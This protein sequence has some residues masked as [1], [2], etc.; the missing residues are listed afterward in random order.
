MPNDVDKSLLDRLQALRGSSVTPERISSKYTHLSERKC[1]QTHWLY[2]INID[3]IERTRTPTREDALA[4]RLKSLRSQDTPSP[5]A[6]RQQPIAEKPIRPKQVT[7]TSSKEP[8]SPKQDPQDQAEDDDEAMFR[9][10]DNVLEELLGDVDTE[11]NYAKPT[12]PSDD[13]VKAFLEELSRSVPQNDAAA[14][15]SAD[16]EDKDKDSDDSDGQDMT[17]E[18]DDVVA[19]FRDEAEVDA[20]HK[21]E[22][23]SDEE[24]GQGGDKE[25]QDQTDTDLA[26][27]SVPS[28]LQD[29]PSSPPSSAPRDI[30]D[31]TS[32]LAALR[33]SPS[34]SPSS[35][36]PSVPTSRPAKAPKR[37][38]SKTNY[39]DDD[40][41]GWCTVCLEDATLRCMGC[42]KDPYCAR[43][44]HEMHVGPSA[45]F[46][47]R[48][49]K[50]VQFTKDRKK[51]EKK[52]ALGA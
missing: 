5:P 12:E 14:D 40:M 32:R 48:G 38:T 24:S 3:T 31:I 36:F 30:N 52:V 23:S 34:P 7:P 20:A 1:I 44:W 4:D 22:E 39:A 26:L 43:C 42:D 37:L 51:K 9:T 17:R 21:K 19:R 29:I 16:G 8:F 50:A 33:T 15:K 2:R 28:T 46:D 47:E 27:P 45:G 11:E 49:H 35:E 18:V 13:Q 10:D 25:E 41:D 6:S